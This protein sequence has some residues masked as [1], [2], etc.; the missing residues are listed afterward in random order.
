MPTTSEVVDRHMK[1]FAERDLDG[2][3]AD[4]SPDAVL[5]TP[6]RRLK[7]LATSSRFSR[8]FWRS[9]PSPAPRFRCGSEALTVITPTYC[10]PPN[11]RTIPT[12]WLPTPSLC[13]TGR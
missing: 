6:G 1:C 13:A 2:V 8:P 4:Y 10:G 7:A 12:N 11:P 5:F 9:S 3:L